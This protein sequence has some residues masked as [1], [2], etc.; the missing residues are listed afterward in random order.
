MFCEMRAR[1]GDASCMD[2]HEQSSRNDEERKRWDAGLRCFVEC[3]VW[4]LV[5]M[6]ARMVGSG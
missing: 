3:G 2:C 1:M 5:D 4:M 6:C